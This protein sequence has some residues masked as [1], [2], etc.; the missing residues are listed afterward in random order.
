MAPEQTRRPSDVLGRHTDIYLLGGILYEIV[1]GR[2]P[3]FA[4][5]AKEAYQ[6][7]CTN[8]YDPPPPETPVELRELIDRSLATAAA[9]RPATAEEF[10][11]AID[12]YLNG[13]RRRA[14]SRELTAAVVRELTQAEVHADRLSGAEWRAVTS[15]ADQSPIAAGAGGGLAVASSLPIA[16]P[17][18]AEW[19][20]RIVRALA[21]WPDNAEAAHLADR[22]HTRHARLAIG[23]GDL[24]L[25]GTLLDT[26][27]ADAPDRAK[28]R[29]ELASAR[30]RL[31]RRERQRRLATAAIAILLLALVASGAFIY[32]D[33][34]QAATKIATQQAR[35]E[36]QARIARLL[37]EANELIA[38]ENAL[39][40]E[41][42]DIAPMPASLDDFIRVDRLRRERQKEPLRR[43]VGRRQLLAE[44]RRRLEREL[45]TD[46]AAF[47]GEE[48]FG[49]RLAE[50]TAAMY[51]VTMPGSGPAAEPIDGPA[52][53]F[54]RAAILF[55]QAVADRADSVEARV[56]LGFASYFTGD[57]LGAARIF[58]QAADLVALR[59]G[60]DSVEFSDA[61]ALA[62]QAYSADSGLE[63]ADDQSIPF[64]GR[65]AEILQPRWER[66]TQQ[67]AQRL[68]DA[69]EYQRALELTS[70][71]LEV[72]HDTNLAT[73]A[74]RLNLAD[75]HIEL[76]FRLA[77]FDE[78]WS[79]IDR[80][81]RDMKELEA[82]NPESLDHDAWMGLLLN[83]AQ[84][85]SRL[86]RPDESLAYFQQARRL[87]EEE[88]RSILEDYGYSLI[89]M[90]A[91][92]LEVLGRYQEADAQLVA[93]L[94]EMAA[95][96]Y[97][98]SIQA[99]DV[100]YRIGDLAIFQGDPDR[101]IDFLNRSNDIYSKLLPPDHLKL[102]QGQFGLGRLYLSTG[103]SAEAV[104]TL[105]RVLEGATR[106]YGSSHP[107]VGA[108]GSALAEAYYRVGDIA[109]S[110]ALK[111]RIITESLATVGLDHPD[112]ITELLNYSGTLANVMQYED[113]IV[114]NEY[115]MAIMRQ[116]LGPR[117]PFTRIVH[118]RTISVPLA[119]IGDGGR[120]DAARMI[121]LAAE[122][123]RYYPLDN[124]PVADQREQIA[125][126]TPEVTIL[127]LYA[128]ADRAPADSPASGDAAE[129]EPAALAI[130]DD[131]ARAA[132]RRWLLLQ[133][134]GDDYDGIEEAM[135]QQ[136]AAASSSS[137]PAPAE[138]DE[139][140]ATGDR[141]AGT[142]LRGATI[143]G[144]RMASRLLGEEER[145]ALLQ[146]GEAIAAEVASRVR[147]VD[148][149]T[150]S[151]DDDGA[152]DPVVEPM[153]VGE[154]RARLAS[155][156]PP[157]D[158]EE[159]FPAITDWSIDPDEARLE[160]LREHIL[161]IF[162]APAAPGDE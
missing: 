72:R 21:L 77:E 1:T 82:E 79:M 36:E 144:Q 33:R 25:A 3:H 113:A 112:T 100:L 56:G 96:G 154:V 105:E 95:K 44:Q 48:P 106:I 16:Y 23:Q 9:E 63:V 118:Q 74:N 80:L 114:I 135:R 108:A 148:D 38:A 71:A 35:A 55:G 52:A 131:I 54:A 126:L 139:D 93:L 67:L 37:G 34:R 73:D 85:S 149:A 138:H 76:L 29:G 61:L 90:E 60:E 102:V 45:P 5:T 116:V 125:L 140:A 160:A 31:A 58:E 57:P 134:L 92:T 94:E 86:G 101:A 17:V 158:C 133:P 53:G 107:H 103:R 66:M 98:K 153:T 157:I 30:T 136:E 155:L 8:D 127:M 46:S 49:L 28:L 14:E 146:Q 130:S 68:M 40:V 27:P 111:R 89:F 99:A 162:T 123:A 65:S 10:R 121:R 122:F 83:R 2:G 75:L 47:L 156:A 119:T 120:P 26:M 97:D 104:D 81:E 88:G 145:R 109:K 110:F 42:N 69:S 12:A 150:N 39:I 141:I 159:A 15:A 161:A 13:S 128:A 32:H 7:A 137:I 51:G 143:V 132:L 84:V 59:N 147:I 19:R 18:L 62:G 87:A 151:P 11:D 22:L 91:Q 124:A 64:Y 41:I 24:V 6:R 115:C 129:R 78:S 142:L 70:A 117:H 43:L 50:A 4:L 20:S 152:G